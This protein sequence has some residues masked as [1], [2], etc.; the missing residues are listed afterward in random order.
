MAVGHF[1]TR[2]STNNIRRKRKTM[3]LDVPRKSIMDYANR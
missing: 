3:S 1:R 2:K